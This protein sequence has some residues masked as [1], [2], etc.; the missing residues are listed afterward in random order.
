M[1]FSESFSKRRVWLNGT[2]VGFFPWDW[3]VWQI[4][5]FCT[6]WQQSA[7]CVIKNFCWQSQHEFNSSKFL[8]RV[9]RSTLQSSDGLDLFV[10]LAVQTFDSSKPVNYVFSV[11]TPEYPLDTIYEVMR[12]R[13]YAWNTYVM[14]P[15]SH[16]HRL[17]M[18]SEAG[19]LQVKWQFGQHLHVHQMYQ[20]LGMKETGPCQWRLFLSTLTKMKRFPSTIA[21]SLSLEIHSQYRAA[22][23]G[24]DFPFV[25]VP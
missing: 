25:P 10:A 21:T 9:Q 13:N 20:L 4:P 7:A 3:N 2:S 8:L 24:P 15:D 16:A 23:W 22:A 5:S 14:C 18:A 19:P 11:P 1:P 12:A 6:V 17:S